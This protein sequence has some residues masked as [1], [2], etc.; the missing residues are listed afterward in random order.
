M[1]EL[2]LGL[3]AGGWASDGRTQAWR[4]HDEPLGALAGWARAI[5]EAQ[6]H[7]WA[8]RWRRV[9][10]DLRLS[11]G[12][13]RPLLCGPV[14]GLHRWPEAEALAA[15]TAPDATGLAGPCR[16][17]LEDW[18]GDGM[19]LATAVDESLAALVDALPRAHR[20]RW[21][22]VRPC[23]A[24]ALDEALRQRPDLRLFAFAEADALTLLGGPAREVGAPSFDQAATHAPSPERD[25]AGA[26][27]QRTLLARDVPSDEALFV[28]LATPEVEAEAS[29]DEGA[30]GCWPAV[31]SHPEGLVS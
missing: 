28:Q 22:S 27:W 19:A 24:V 1:I 16:A 13:A 17:L 30:R 25:H 31:V 23:W 7:S 5:A 20:I 6:T 12:L 4:A 14:D 26:L 11:G 21:R 10:I 9:S 8:R 18:P 29:P 2:Y 3:H 15:A